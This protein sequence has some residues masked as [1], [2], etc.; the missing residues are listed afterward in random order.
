MNNCIDFMDLHIHTLY[1]DGEKN[2]REILEES[3]KQGL[4]V[5][6]ITDHNSYGA[7]FELER[8]NV[9]SIFD[10]MIIPGCEFLVNFEGAT[11]EILVYGGKWKELNRWLMNYYS[12][13]NI[14]KRD[15]KIFNSILKRIREEH[16][17]TV[18]KE[19]SL[20][21][22][23]PYSGYYKYF[24]Y[25]EL[26]KYPENRSFFEKYS[27]ADYRDFNRKGIDNKKSEIYVN[28]YDKDIDIKSVIDLVH[29][30]NR[31]CL[32]CARI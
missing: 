14:N 20:P 25:N 8:T 9:R 13:E 15:R 2:V 21:E 10:G 1:S 22:D 6:S 32:S 19:L 23:I 18:S 28:V 11:I 29:R 31:N 27:I 26:K 17:I 16:K 30:N 12:Q 7:H 4:K 5:I 24:L 3:N